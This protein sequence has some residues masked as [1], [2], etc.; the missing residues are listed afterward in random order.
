MQDLIKHNPQMFVGLILLWIG[1]SWIFVSYLIG[2][3]SGWKRLSGR[4]RLQQTYTGPKWK[5]Q[6][7]QMRKFA[8]YNN[9]LIV[10]ADPMGLFLSIN[11]LFR[12][13][14]P[15]LF[16][17]WNE[18]MIPA[19]DWSSAARMEMRLGQNEQVP[20]RIE[21]LLASQLRDA[22]GQGWPLTSAF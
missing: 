22:A 8:S 3:A 19:Q 1:G 16:I 7:A 18:V 12:L 21:G 20:F 17:P 14:H 15:A 4:F 5:W 10:G 6:S 13:G 9:C 11:V 2:L